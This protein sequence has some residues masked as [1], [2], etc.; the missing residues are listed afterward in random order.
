MEAWC[1]QEEQTMMCH[2]FDFTS[3]TTEA[4]DVDWVLLSYGWFWQFLLIRRD[5]I[6]NCLSGTGWE[7]NTS[8]SLFKLETRQFFHKPLDI[9]RQKRPQEKLP[10]FFFFFPTKPHLLLLGPD[11]TCDFLCHI[12]FFSTYVQEVLG[13]KFLEAATTEWESERAVKMERHWNMLPT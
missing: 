7:K 10:G 1:W 12:R 11:F 4:S 8:S 3:V 13:T 2:A 5:I 9:S 6:G